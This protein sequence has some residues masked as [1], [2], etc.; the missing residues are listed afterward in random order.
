MRIVLQRFMS[1]K[2]ATVGGLYIDCPDT[3]LC[4]ILEDEHRTKK[5]MSETRIPS[6][7]Y[8]I[9]LRCEGGH[10]NRYLEKYKDVHK[11]GRYGMLCIHSSGNDEWKIVTP[12]ME[13][14]YVLIH[15]G[16]NDDHTA[17]CLLT[18][19]TPTHTAFK[20]K[21]QISNSTV[22]YKQIYL[23]I[24]DKLLSGERVYLDVYDEGQMF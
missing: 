21:G 23:K 9:S 1:N 13:F 2:E 20:E 16:N 5:V 10:Y 24:A 18:G 15:I 8:E 6:G 17:G 11:D 3:P 12:T 19:T 7:S 22:A 4:F 14:Q